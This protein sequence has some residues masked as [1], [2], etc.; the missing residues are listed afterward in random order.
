MYI[1]TGCVGHA[2]AIS[3]SLSEQVVYFGRQDLLEDICSGH[4]NYLHGAMVTMFG[5]SSEL[6][7][8]S[9]TVVDSGIKSTYTFSSGLYTA[10]ASSF[11]V[12]HAIFPDKSFAKSRTWR[13]ISTCS[14]VKMVEAIL[15]NKGKWY[16][17]MTHAV[18]YW[19]YSRG[20]RTRP[21][22]LPTMVPTIMNT[23][24]STY[25]SPRSPISK[26]RQRWA[27]PPA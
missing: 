5:L 8:S 7:Q 26:Y 25:P 22:K 1:I 19:R 23:A 16:P 6:F 4:V 21:S 17:N 13:Q 27:T 24:S 9:R 10:M 18:V 15:R 20:C 3:G 11:F 12:G 14:R 2:A